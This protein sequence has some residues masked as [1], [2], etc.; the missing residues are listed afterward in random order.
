MTKKNKAR[1]NILPDFR[2]YYKATVTNSMILAQ[3]L[4]HKAMEQNRE[5]RIK[6]M[7]LLTYGQLIYKQRGKNIQ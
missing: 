6:P 3:K 4:T 1:G 5:P 2:L 7:H